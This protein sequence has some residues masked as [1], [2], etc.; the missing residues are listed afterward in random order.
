MEKLIELANQI[1]DVELRKKVVD[2]LKDPKLSHKDFKKY[3]RED[4][5]KVKT[6][7]TISNIGTVERGDLVNHTIV[8]ANLCMKTAEEIKKNYGVDINKDYLLAGAILHDIMKI[9]EWK[10]NKQGPEHTG[11]LLDH[12]MLAVAEFYARGFPE[13]VIHIVAAHFG[14]G[15][16]T[17]P[18][19]FEALILH[20]IDTLVSLTE[21][22]LQG[23]K[24]QQPL[25]VLV[26][27]EETI[28]K[29]TKESE[30]KS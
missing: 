6:P 26:L 14:E 25:Q 19:N 1:E 22:Y 23:V 13:Q 9:Y 5:N 21:F 8:V 20:Y 4:I 30:G 7:F 27:D 24:P 2:F 16:P 18:R 17:P 15:S 12:S 28:K 29:I 3:P 11:I 10:M